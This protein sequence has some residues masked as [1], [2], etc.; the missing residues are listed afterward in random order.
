MKLTKEQK[1]EKAAKLAQTLK[2]SAHIYFTQYQGLKFKEMDDLRGKLRPLGSSY[3]V[4]KNSILAHALKDAGIKVEGENGLLGGPNALLIGAEDDPVSPVRILVNFAKEFEALKVK[5][6]Y[7][8]GK[9]LGPAE[10]KALSALG[11]KPEVL[12]K[13]AHALYSAVAQSAWVL[14]APIRDMV[15]VLQALEE[16][17]KSEAAA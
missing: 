8:D 2:A 6:G 1:K 10:C 13:L 15:L 12:G 14:A 3:K 7:V 17:K 11:T 16:K 4:Y 5:G 9:W